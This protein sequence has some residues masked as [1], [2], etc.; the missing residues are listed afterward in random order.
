M[1]AFRHAVYEYKYKNWLSNRETVGNLFTREQLETISIL[2]L[3]DTHISVYCG[4]VEVLIKQLQQAVNSINGNRNIIPST[5]SKTTMG[6]RLDL[7]T[8]IYNDYSPWTAYKD[9]RVAYNFIRRHGKTPYVK[10]KTNRMLIAFEDYIL[11]LGS[12]TYGI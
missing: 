9:G 10:R 2:T 8:G 4:E 3:Q 7:Y 1:N 6:T 11:T 5:L 12:I